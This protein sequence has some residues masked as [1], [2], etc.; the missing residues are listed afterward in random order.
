MQFVNTQIRGRVA[1]VIKIA[2]TVNFQENMATG[3]GREALVCQRVKEKLDAL[4]IINLDIIHTD[5]ILWVYCC[6]CS[7]RIK[8]NIPLSVEGQSQ[9]KFMVQSI[10]K[11]DNAQHP[12]QQVI[13]VHFEHLNLIFLK[14]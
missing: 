8:N 2:Y 6:L 5:Y 14:S 12:S 4:I 13:L 11:A 1:G 9:L 3:E 7:I 10:G